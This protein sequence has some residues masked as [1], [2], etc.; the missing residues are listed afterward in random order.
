MAAAMAAATVAA[1]MAVAAAAAEAKRLQIKPTCWTMEEVSSSASAAS[2]AANSD[3]GSISSCFSNADSEAQPSASTA[4]G[5][6]IGLVFV[7]KAK[8]DACTP[9]EL[10][11]AFRKNGITASP[12]AGVQDQALWAKNELWRK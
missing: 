7:G 9:E 1:A 8:L 4:S 12:F 6:P 11:L 3:D 10:M 2:S 5:L